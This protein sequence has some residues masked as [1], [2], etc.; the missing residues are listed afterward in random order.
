MPTRREI[1][2][3]VERLRRE[4]RRAAVEV[5][6][7]HLRELVARVDAAWNRSF[8]KAF[9][10][11]ADAVSDLLDSERGLAALL[12]DVTQ[13]GVPPLGHYGWAS[14]GAATNVLSVFST[15][16]GCL[17]DAG[18]PDA[19]LEAARGIVEAAA[20]RTVLAAS[21]QVDA[22][23][24][25]VERVELLLHAVGARR[26]FAV[27][28]PVG[29]SLPTKVVVSSLLPRGFEIEAVRISLSRN[30]SKKA[31]RRRV[32]ILREKLSAAGT[33]P[34]DVV[35]LV[36]EWVTGANFKAITKLVSAILRDT[37]ATFAPFA[38][39]AD[40]ASSDPRYER[41]TTRHDQKTAGLPGEPVDFR[42]VV[43]ELPVELTALPFFWS[44]QDRIAG[45]RKMQVWG[46]IFSSLHEAVEHLAK[47]E[48]ARRNAM[49]YCIESGLDAGFEQ[50]VDGLRKP[51]V[52]DEMYE[53][54]FADYCARADELRGLAAGTQAETD[55]P[56]EPSVR[57]VV[58]LL[59]RRLEG[60]RAK[61]C[62]AAASV[63]LR[64]RKLIEPAD[65]Y[66]FRSHVPMVAELEGAYAAGART[67][68]GYLTDAVVRRLR[69]RG[70][71]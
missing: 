9:A 34:D 30:D 27:E 46:S 1:Q 62:V 37:G 71:R 17:H 35:L 25:L 18:A 32:D 40:S 14:A 52:F 16:S 63:Y 48:E 26:V 19:L 2:E 45:Y 60:T 33:G 6:Y 38:L 69:R 70:L 20:R 43:P 39:L 4:R 67:L 64:E 11:E 57:E 56:V 66:Y 21:A 10:A 5:A 53:E 61:L 59:A 3:A 58:D 24:G 44:E 54:A 49:L 55:A 15:F 22:L 13:R 51:E 65:R 8:A 29:N 23:V 36:D 50:A 7:A 68:L 41:F 28:L 31:G 47:N 12:V 42:I